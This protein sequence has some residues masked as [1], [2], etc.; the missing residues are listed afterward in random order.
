MFLSVAPESSSKHFAVFLVAGIVRSNTLTITFG[1]GAL[2]HG[3]PYNFAVVLALTLCGIHFLLSGSHVYY[4]CLQGAFPSFLPGLPDI[5]SSLE[6]TTMMFCI[7]GQC[8]S[9]QIIL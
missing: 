4:Q 5:M 1:R 9:P 3:I 7:S 2:D 6:Q 8:G